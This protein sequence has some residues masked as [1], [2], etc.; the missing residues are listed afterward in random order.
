M[1]DEASGGEGA[2]NDGRNKVFVLDKINIYY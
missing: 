2:G 1:I